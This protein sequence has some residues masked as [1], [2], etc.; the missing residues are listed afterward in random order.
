MSTAPAPSRPQLLSAA[1]GPGLLA[2]FAAAFALLALTPRVQGHDGLLLSFGLAGGLVVAWALALLV[3]ARVRGTPLEVELR[4]RKPHAIQTLAQ[5]VVYLSWGTFWDPVAEMLPLFA[6]QIVFA[7]LFEMALTWT[8]Y[9]RFR[10]GL[11]PLPVVGSYNLFMWFHDDVFVFQFAMLTLA[12]LSREYLRRRVPSPPGAPDAPPATAHIFNPSAFG[13][14]TTGLILI[15]GGWT[16]LTWGLQIA[17]SHGYGPHAY[18]FIFLAG[19]VVQLAVPVV[20]I[21]SSAVLSSLALEA[22]YHAFT[23][24]H[25]YVDTGVPIA[26]FLGMTLL[27]TDPA[28]TPKSGPGKV[29]FGVLYGVAVF[30]LY[31]ALAQLGR[32][33]HDGLPAVHVTYFDKLLHLPL[34]NLLAPVCDRLTGRLAGRKRWTRMTDLQAQ[35][36]HVIAWVV[37]FAAVLPRLE[38]HP[39]RQQNF[40][41]LRFGL[42]DA[43]CT[44][45]LFRCT[46]A[47]PDHPAHAARCLQRCFE[48]LPAQRRA[49]VSRMYHCLRS[50]SDFDPWRGCTKQIFQCD[51]G[52][53]PPVDGPQ[54]GE[55]ARALAPRMAP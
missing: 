55:P 23:G 30:V 50:N 12:W 31:T 14:A 19:I 41:R 20:L 15:A 28:S 32:P 53:V 36:L 13:L 8:R 44:A 54:P 52:G 33:A 27:V 49:Q 9:G 11:G 39:G 34:L 18:A 24:R 21:T 1:W 45:P 29:L 7:Y 51:P 2:L 17:V 35:R 26:V 3:R 47:C 38:A 43:P 22:T 6:A 25:Y 10:L 40:A 16:H 5:A 42:N 46:P 48:R 4:V 37:V